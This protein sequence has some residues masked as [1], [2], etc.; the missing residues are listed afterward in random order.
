[1]QSLFD[2]ADSI[3]FTAIT[4]RGRP[5]SKDSPDRFEKICPVLL[6]FQNCPIWLFTHSLTLRV[7]VNSG[8]ELRWF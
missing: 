7:K 3:R 6:M 8:A 1:M 5:N 2:T 4:I